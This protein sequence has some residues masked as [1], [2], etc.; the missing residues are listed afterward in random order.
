MTALQAL[1][2]IGMLVQGQSVVL[3]DMK[4]CVS[5]LMSFALRCNLAMP[6]TCARHC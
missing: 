4:L 3:R 1:W 6:H 5:T 2:M